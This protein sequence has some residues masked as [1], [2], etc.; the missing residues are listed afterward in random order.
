M[1]EVGLE[2][3]YR[4]SGAQFLLDAGL[5]VVTRVLAEKFDYLLAK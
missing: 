4:F 1:L 2:E 5:Q 3:H